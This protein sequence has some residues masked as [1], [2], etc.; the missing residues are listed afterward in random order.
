VCYN[1]DNMRERGRVL[2]PFGSRFLFFVGSLSDSKN[3]GDLW[4]NLTD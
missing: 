1:L 3:K 2:I 4:D